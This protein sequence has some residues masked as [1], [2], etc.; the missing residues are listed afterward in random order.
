MGMNAS[1]LRQEGL[2]GLKAASRSEPELRITV[3]VL[4]VSFHINGRILL[5][6]L[7]ICFIV[8]LQLGN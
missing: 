2:V 4:N 8:D 6:V 5:P 3:H 1:I 7:S